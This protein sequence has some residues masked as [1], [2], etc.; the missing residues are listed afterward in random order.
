MC[1]SVMWVVSCDVHFHFTVTCDF[2]SC[3]LLRGPLNE[4]FF[5]LYMPRSMAENFSALPPLSP[6]WLFLLWNQF[7]ILKMGGLVSP[8]WLATT[9]LP[10]S[11]H[12]PSFR[13]ARAFTHQGF[14]NWMAP[15]QLWFQKGAHSELLC[16]LAFCLL[17]WSF[18][19]FRDSV[20][21]RIYVR[22]SYIGFEMRQTLLFTDP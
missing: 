14:R 4:S 10:G 13:V 3:S 15:I 7:A 5:D 22:T 8:L 16:C 6:F 17:W 18:F 20:R 9:S 1:L 11:F 12:D 19:T 21:L 2:I